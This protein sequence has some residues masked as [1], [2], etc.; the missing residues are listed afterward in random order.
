MRAAANQQARHRAREHAPFACG[1]CAVRAERARIA[2][3]ASTVYSYT[4]RRAAAPGG[5]GGA[6]GRRAVDREG[7]GR[8]GRPPRERDVPRTA[9][10]RIGRAHVRARCQTSHEGHDRTDR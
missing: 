4:C 9:R 7:R 5:A 10:P 8:R 6:R 2:E 3:R 1:L